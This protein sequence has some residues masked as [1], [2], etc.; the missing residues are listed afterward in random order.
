MT[1]R[2]GFRHLSV[3]RPLLGSHLLTC[4]TLEA[5]TFII[6]IVLHRGAGP[7]HRLHLVVLVT[8]GFPQPA[9]RTLTCFSRFFVSMFFV[10]GASCAGG[11]GQVAGQAPDR[12]LEV[13]QVS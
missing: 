8:A 12:S 5:L 3:F 4:I 9:T 7:A 2:F 6:Q 1:W 13:V 11:V 10:L